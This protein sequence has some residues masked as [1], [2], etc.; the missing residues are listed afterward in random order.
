MAN[1]MDPVLRHHTSQER[2]PV[3]VPEIHNNQPHQSPK[4]SHAENHTEQIEATRGEDH[5]W[6]TGRLQSRKEHHSAALQPT[7]PLWK[8]LQHQQDLYHV[9]IDF[10]NAFNRIWHVALWATMKKYNISTNLIWVIKN[11]HD[12]VTS[13]VLFNGTIGDWVQTTVGVRQGCL[14]SPTLFNTF[15]ERTMTDALEDHEST[16]SIGSRAI[17]NLGFADDIDNR[18]GEE[19]ELAKL[20]ER[21]EKAS[22]SYGMDSSAEKTK[23]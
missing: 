13:A 16:V 5:R 21:L 17:T 1:I 23:L 20:V 6:R 18:S 19:E 15:L 4:Q 11:L 3:A 9:F 14:L 2:Q 10:K 7:D 8:Y 22:K 12:K